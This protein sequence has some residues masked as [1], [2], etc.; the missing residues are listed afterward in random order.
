MYICIYMYIYV[1][2]YTHTPT[3]KAN[4]YTGKLFIL[5]RAGAPGF[6]EVPGSAK[7]KQRIRQ[8]PAMRYHLK[9]QTRSRGSRVAKDFNC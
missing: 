5:A 6:L 3:R 2:I 9:T 4:P 1:Y 8:A 7:Q